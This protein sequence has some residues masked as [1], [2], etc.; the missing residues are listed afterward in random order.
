MPTNSSN[1]SQGE[2]EKKDLFH[3]SILQTAMDG[4]WLID[5]LGKLKEV[6]KAYCLMSGY[7]EQELLSM[8]ITD[9]ETLETSENTNNYLKH[10]KQNGSVRFETQHR[11][12]NGNI[13]DVE[14]SAQ[15]KQLDDDWYVVFIRDI[16]AQKNANAIIAK[17]KNRLEY[18]L[19]SIETGACEL[20]LKMFDSWRMFKH[21]QIFGY[22]EPLDEWTYEMFL[23]HV[24]PEDRDEVNQ[25]FQHALATKTDWNF[26]CRIKRN[27]DGKVRWIWANG[28]HEFDENREYGKM[29]GIVQDIT[30]RKQTEIKL[31]DSQNYLSVVFNNT[32]DAQLL[33][34]SEGNKKFTVS[35]VNSSYL[36]KLNYLGLKVSESDIVG[37][38]LKDVIINTLFLSEEICEYTLNYYQQA[39][40]TAKQIKNLESFELNEKM[41][42]SET[43]Y[44]PIFKAEDNTSYILYTSHDRTNETESNNLLQD[45]EERFSI[46]VS[47]SNDAIWDWNNLESD[48]YWWSDRLYEILGYKPSEVEAR[49]SNWVKWMHPNDAEHVT[50][51]LNNHLEKDLPY[52]VEFRM[53]RKDGEY[54][55]LFA[56]GE[57]I[58]NKE[59][60]PIRMAG[61]VTDITE[62][63]QAEVEIHNLL[64]ES[65]KGAQ[66]LRT[67]LADEKLAREQ[68]KK[69]NDELEQKVL[70]RT[71]E[72]KATNKE[73][74]TF[75]YSVSHD[76]K[77]PL[78]GIDG[79]SKLLQ[80]SYK[81]KLDE[82]ANIFLTNIR[83]SALKMNQLIND[84]LDYSRLERS[85]LNNEKINVKKLINSITS[86]FQ[87][88][89][90]E[91]NFEV[92]I[93]IEEQEIEADS[94]GL[95]IALQNMI[96]NAIK[97]TK[98]QDNPTISI[99]M[100]NK[101]KSLIISIKDNGIGFDIKYKQKIFDIFQRLHRAEDYPG[102]GIGLA[103]V[104]KAMQ[105]MNGKSWA[106]SSINMG[107][108]FYI[109][110]PKEL[111]YE[112]KK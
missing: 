60:K 39:I 48:E 99:D 37:K 32:I 62:R 97:F 56:R 16:T 102:T 77:A 110:I 50:E 80:D 10:V 34:R 47:G 44:T 55:W 87:K 58:R 67:A 89:L 96:E 103:L 70:E 64:D 53:K 25:K 43:S 75:T 94:K 24:I 109:E 108:T 18:A 52:K 98:E 42:H 38:S 46:A 13:F 76:L 100:E 95:S 6:N 8:N 83:S 78:R 51:V 7:S 72:L 88:E 5:S 12:R 4:F 79:Y 74:E 92:N 1:R 61:S 85:H 45:S 82:E 19:N 69:L 33:S 57:T 59:G 65:K 112:Y 111:K 73:L 93:N 3:Q 2:A 41:Y 106:E 86:I 81:N 21:D 84:L 9:L 54:V 22:A 17:N 107:S 91:N 26:E 20:D 29:F 28:S 40:D 27:D 66:A 15:Y 11:G 36:K 104:N 90:D 71:V 31:L 49:I 68:I 63:K 105:R 30:K 35:A 101:N 14:I 23:E